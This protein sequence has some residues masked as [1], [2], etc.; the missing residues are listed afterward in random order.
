MISFFINKSDEQQFLEY[1]LSI[2]IKYIKR[3]G[4][5]TYHDSD[6]LISHV[7]YSVL[8]NTT[9]LTALKLKFNIKHSLF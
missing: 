8:I 2:G 1:L 3:V 9:D 5:N 6:K 4:K 7:Q